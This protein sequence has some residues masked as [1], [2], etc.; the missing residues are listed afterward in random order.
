MQKLDVKSEPFEPDSHPK[1]RVKKQKKDE[2]DANS[3]GIPENLNRKGQQPKK[4]KKN[5]SK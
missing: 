2:A 3:D 5:N 1:Y 4:D